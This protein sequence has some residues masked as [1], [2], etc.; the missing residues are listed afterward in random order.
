MIVQQGVLN[1]N[2]FLVRVVSERQGILANRAVDG[3]E[4]PSKSLLPDKY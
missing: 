2:A 1:S 3:Y 4:Q